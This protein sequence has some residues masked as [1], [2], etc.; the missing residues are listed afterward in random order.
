MPTW[1]SN[2]IHY[3]V[4]D[5]ISYP[6]PNFNGITVE[7]WE[8][9]SIFIL[10][11]TGYVMTYPCWDLSYTM[12]VKGCPE[13]PVTQAISIDSTDYKV[14]YNLFFIT[15]HMS[16]CQ[17]FLFIK[18][19]LAKLLTKFRCTSWGRNTNRD[20]SD[21]CRWNS[22]L[23]GKNARPRSSQPGYDFV[24]SCPARLPT[25]SVQF[26]FTQ[27]QG[28][29]YTKSLL[30]QGVQRHILLTIFQSKFELIRFFV[31]LSSK[32]W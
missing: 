16:C 17:H 25:S 21:N 19:H 6:F 4:C 1:R 29:S 15:S 8:W 23:R 27:W 3:K 14:W 2:Y 9:I 13:V 31:L 28:S 26:G 20:V 22:W 30:G 24:L 5:E 7:V 10:H 12:T 32:I 11:F 18:H